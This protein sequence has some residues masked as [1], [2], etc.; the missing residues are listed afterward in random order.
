MKLY[1][2]YVESKI[3][4]TAFK[5]QDMAEKLLEDFALTPKMFS[6][7][8][9]YPNLLTRE[10]TFKEWFAT[11]TDDDFERTKIGYQNTERIDLEERSSWTCKKEIEIFIAE[12]ECC[13][14]FKLIKYN[15]GDFFKLHKD[16]HG[17]HTCLI[18]CPSDFK[19]GTL[20]LKKN[21]LCEIHIRPEVMQQ[22]EYDCYTMLT[23]S[24]DFLHEV[25]PITEGV[26]YVL[27]AT[28]DDDEGSEEE[29]QNEYWEGG[30]DAAYDDY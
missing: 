27:K 28:I 29:L 19:G 1:S 4:F 2:T 11:L 16:S 21:D 18:F 24:T 30:L 13:L 25:T 6:V 14:T 15:V 7:R 8:T 22:V 23:F 10:G 26:R 20:K 5:K 3:S 17:T 12:L 9:I